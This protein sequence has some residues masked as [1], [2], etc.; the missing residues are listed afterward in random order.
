MNLTKY[1]LMAAALAYKR[2]SFVYETLL[3]SHNISYPSN[4]ASFWD[5]IKLDEN[6]FNLSTLCKKSKECPSFDTF[7]KNRKF[8]GVPKL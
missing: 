3:K 1:D 6:C 7:L 8:T 4:L 5:D 2:A